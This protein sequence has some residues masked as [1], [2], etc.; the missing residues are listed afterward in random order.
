M[1]HKNLPLKKALLAM[2]LLCGFATVKAQTPNGF[3]G[4]GTTNPKAKLDISSDTSGI[5]IPR[6]AT[7][8][9]ADAVLP[10]LNA[11]DHTGLLIFIA[12]TPNQGFWF[13]DG[14]AWM[15]SK[16]QQGLQG[17]QGL[18]GDKGD[19]GTNGTIGLTGATGLQG[20]QG[21][22]GLK[23]DKGDV[24]TTGATG[25]QGLQGIQG[26][27][28]DKGDIGT[29]GANGLQGLQGIQGLKGDK[30]D[31]GTTGAN[32]LQG[33]QGAKGDT[34]V[35]GKGVPVGGTANQVLA[36]IDG[37]NYN[38]QWVTP[39]SGGGASELQK[40]TQAGKT[41]FRILGWDTTYNNPTGD[42]AINL[43][44]ND[45]LGGNGGAS[46][47][48]SFAT[49][50]G[51]LA[52]G[53]YSTAMGQYSKATA[54]SSTSLGVQSTASGDKSLATGDNTI[55]SGY[56]STAMGGFTTAS[57][58]N[59]TTMGYNTTASGANSTAMG[60]QTTASENSSTAMGINTKASG[61]VATAV[62]YR[63]KAQ[64]AGEMA[65][66]I[67]NDTLTFADGVNT[68]LGVNDSNRVF[69]VGNG[70]DQHNIAHT[71]FVIQRNGNIGI[72]QRR[73]SEKLDIAGSIKIVDGT[74]GVGKVLTSDADGKATWQTA[75]GASELQK[76]TEAGNTGWRILGRDTS[77][78]GNIGI[79]AIDFSSSTSASS[80]K[81]A[82]G[83][84]STAYGINT[85]AS[86]YSSSAMGTSTIASG[87]NS[88]TMGNNTIASGN[89]STA[90]GAN[91]IASGDNSFAIGVST[92]ATA[93]LST[94]M[95]YGTIA[96]GSRAT[97]SGEQ[98][99]AKS[100]TETSIGYY[101]DTLIAVQ[102]YSASSDSNRL[103]TVGNGTGLSTRKT[104]FVIQQ[105]GNIGINQRRPS[106]KLDIAGSIK[107]VDGTQGVG[108]VLTSDANG[109]ASWATAASGGAGFF[110]VSTTDANQIIYNSNTN[111]GK[112][113]IVNADSTN[114]GSGVESKMF[115]MPS[116]F[117][118][119]AGAIGNK[120]WDKDSIGLYS[121]ASG[122][123]TIAK[124]IASTALGWLTTASGQNST[125]MGQN[126]TASGNFSTAMGLNS[127]ASGNNS[128]A[129]GNT[130]I[131]SGTN[132]TTMG[133]NTT[134][135]G[136]NSTAMGNFTTASGQN[137]TAMG[138]NT[139]ASS[140]SSTA[141]GNSTTASGYASTAM[142][143]QTIATGDASLAMGYATKAKS[144]GEVVIGSYNDTLTSVNAGGYIGTFDRVFTVGSGT[145]S[146]R[147]TAFVIQQNGRVGIGT[148]TTAITKGLLQIEGSVDYNPNQNIGYLNGGGSVGSFNNTNN[149]PYSIWA[150]QRIAANEFNAFSDVRIKNVIGVSSNTND[151]NTLAKIKITDYTMKD[152]VQ[153]GNKAF[154][155]VI[156]QELKAVY[157]LA[158]NVT[159]NFV[160][161][162]YQKATA[163][164][165]WIALNT[166][167]VKGD[168]VKIITANS[169]KELM[170][171]EVA[172]GKFKVATTDGEVFVY[173]KEV[174]DFHT[175]DYEALSTLNI[176]ATQ[177]LLKRIEEL[178]AKVKEMATLKSD[179]EMIK[180][181]LKISAASVSK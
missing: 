28:G 130:T 123:Y 64:S 103:F 13:Y 129:M 160:P 98:T 5:L 17:I 115:Y 73:P 122:V 158:V 161:N 7:K 181:Q 174:N 143:W 62:G 85:T 106:E 114:W 91:T 44:Y 116:K 24:G 61:Q 10:K 169:T 15:Q 80:T 31:A 71:A 107:I 121:F 45:G 56:N 112:N 110:K 27:K 68:Y 50:F 77:K 42:K 120:N 132:S 21:V 72:N 20:L 125:A 52:S 156:A 87:A 8:A 11:T 63:I 33:I 86:G 117:A 95:G 39:T 111:Y 57:G 92:K 55:A 37:T 151:L 149:T 9:L 49:G 138:S 29:T 88:T 179:I 180:T 126:T 78:Y 46:G 60:F 145:S 79:G 102:P 32:G 147:K 101:N 65:I 100:F 159:T 54:N 99:I 38:T 53:Q 74:Q 124:G 19:A 173:G 168:K 109:K 148:G 26:A 59:S 128:T 172:N 166:D 153:Y 135:S 146:A 105:D 163:S 12:E 136:Q 97:A 75:G 81:G 16:G 2:L 25:I 127:T 76:I 70:D 104:A 176:S 141:M 90:M 139:T 162:I 18:K 175:V 3:V 4:V 140:S 113:F 96:D 66:G 177:A 43:T 119:R 154:K 35:A 89:N 144:F 137:S 142:G 23:G 58:G 157:P 14:L 165:G 47:E 94:A 171:E 150:S 164:N 84:F 131:A 51:S 40:F 108:K 41:G 83:I 22:Q 30:G 152:K 167:L 118:F 155:K 67:Y 6:Y 1:L 82:T 48:I 34:G 36:K 133:Q 134:A 170:V 178:E 69:T 93:F